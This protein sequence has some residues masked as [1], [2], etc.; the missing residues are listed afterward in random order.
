MLIF[1]ITPYTAS[2]SAPS[3]RIICRLNS[4][5]SRPMA[6]SMKKVEKPAVTI[7]RSLPASLAGRTR[8]SV[9]FFEK[10]CPSM[11]AKL[12][13]APKAVARPAPQAPVSSRNTKA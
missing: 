7:C 1:T 2:A 13:A 12:M 8:R 9:F 11:T 10:K 5:V 4:M 3:Q 6:M